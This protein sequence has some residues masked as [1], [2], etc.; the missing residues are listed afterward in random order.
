[1]ASESTNTRTYTKTTS[2]FNNTQ[3]NN[4][5]RDTTFLNKSQLIMAWN[6]KVI[7][8]EHLSIKTQKSKVV[9]DWETS[10]SFKDTQQKRHP[11]FKISPS[12]NFGRLEGVLPNHF[13]ILSLNLVLNSTQSPISRIQSI[14]SLHHFLVPRNL[15][16]FANHRWLWKTALC[17]IWNK[18]HCIQSNTSSKKPK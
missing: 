5:F 17:K 18:R 12:I 14:A 13:Q 1:M 2:V 10:L 6:T 16:H 4:S 3:L 15:V 9:L 7:T 11:L 8:Y